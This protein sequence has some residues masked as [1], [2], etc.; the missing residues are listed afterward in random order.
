[1]IALPW[2]EKQDRFRF[3]HLTIL[4]TLALAPA[5]GQAGAG[6]AQPGRGGSPP[7]PALPSAWQSPSGSYAVVMEEDSTLPDHTIYRPADLSVFPKRERLP[8][9]AFS[10]PGCDY[11]GTA[12]RPFFTEV[13]SHGFLLIANGVPEDQ[14]IGSPGIGQ[15]GRVRER[16]EGEQVLRETRCFKDRRHG[17]VLRRNSDARDF[18]GPTLHRAGAVE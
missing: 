5:F 17:P 14:I 4:C 1:M 8:I 12:F 7:A 6:A 13:A 15:L 16:P 18:P 9:V 2:R 11:N 3:A 10:G